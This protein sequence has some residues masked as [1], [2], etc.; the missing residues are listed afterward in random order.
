MWLDGGVALPGTRRR[1]GLD[2]VLGLVPGL[3]DAVGAVI[4][5]WLLAEG[6]RLGVSRATL[7]RIASN[8]GVD[9]LI[10][11]VPVAGDVFDFA[12]KSNLRN[13]VLLER[14]HVNPAGARRAD[15][16]FVVLLA[17]TL[18]VVC[19]TLMV[20]GALLAGWLFGLVFS[21]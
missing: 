5:L 2:P 6:F 18:L 4:A 14:H 8:I 15:R 3:G 20:G 10:G 7:A 9:A 16:L 19:A 12:W 13:V 1:L 17:G 21:R 11:A